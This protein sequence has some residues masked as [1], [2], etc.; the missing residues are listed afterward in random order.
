MRRHQNYAKCHQKR[1]RAEDR[2]RPSYIL[3][4]SGTS[5]NTH[6]PVCGATKTTPNATKNVTGRK[7]GSVL[8]ISFFGRVR[9]L[10]HTIQYAA[11]PKLRQMPTKMLQGGNILLWSGTSTTTHHP[12]HGATKTT[13]NATKNVT[14]RKIGRV[15]LISFFGRV[16][17]LLHTIQYAAA[18][19]LRQMPPKTLQGGR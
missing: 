1:Y 14:G 11:P 9:Q 16:R 12:V 17:Q 7:I 10:I 19:K 8:L 18:P 3:L 6:H 15:L 4:W 2:K 5:T 13:P